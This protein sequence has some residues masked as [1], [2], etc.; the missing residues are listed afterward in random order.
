[1]SAKDALCYDGLVPELG[2]R[3]RARAA[4]ETLVKKYPSMT[5]SVG[6]LIDKLAIQ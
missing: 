6:S 4:F 3:D 2:V 1:V 5:G